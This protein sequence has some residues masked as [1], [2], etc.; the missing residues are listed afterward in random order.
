MSKE[1]VAKLEQGRLS[2]T[3]TS[4]VEGQKAL[5]KRVKER[6]E[7]R[8]AVAKA[9][10]E[11]IIA[12]TN[13][14][15]Q[16]DEKRDKALDQS[17]KD[18]VSGLDSDQVPTCKKP[19]K[20]E[21]RV[22]QEALA[23]CAANLAAWAANRAKQ[24]GSLRET[25]LEKDAVVASTWFIGNGTGSVGPN[26]EKVQKR[27]KAL[28]AKEKQASSGVKQGLDQIFESIKRV[29]QTPTLETA[30]LQELQQ[31]KA[32][33]SRKIQAQRDDLSQ[34]VE[35][36]REI[37][38]EQW[39]QAQ[40]K[41]LAAE[42]AESE[43]VAQEA[44]QVEDV[45]NE[46]ANVVAL[47]KKQSQENEAEGQQA[48][49]DI[50]S[51]ETL[52]SALQDKT[53]NALVW[54]NMGTL[55][56]N[57]STQALFNSAASAQKDYR[58]LRQLESRITQYF[59]FLGIKNESLKAELRALTNRAIGKLDSIVKDWELQQAENLAQFKR[60]QRL[61]QA[62][63][64]S[65]ASSISRQEQQRLHLAKENWGDLWNQ[66]SLKA[67]KTKEAL[68]QLRRQAQNQLDSLQRPQ[69]DK[70][71]T[72]RL[73][74]LDLENIASSKASLTK[75][76]LDTQNQ[77]SRMVEDNLADNFDIQTGTLESSAEL[78]AQLTS[79]QLKA[80]EA[81]NK[82]NT[83]EFAS[84]IQMSK[85]NDRKNDRD[86]SS[87][88]ED[89]GLQPALFQH[90]AV[91]KEQQQ[92]ASNLRREQALL[93][94]NNL[95]GLQQKNDRARKKYEANLE[96]FR[97]TSMLKSADL[98]ASHMLLAEKLQYS[99]SQAISTWKSKLDSI[100]LALA[101][102]KKDFSQLNASKTFNMIKLQAQH[103]RMQRLWA[104]ELKQLT[105][106]FE[107]AA[108]QEAIN[109]AEEMTE[110]QHFFEKAKRTATAESRKHLAEL[111]AL[112][113]ADMS[114]KKFQALEYQGGL[115]E[116]AELRLRDV[117]G[118]LSDL[119]QRLSQEI[120]D[121]S[122]NNRKL[123]LLQL[124]EGNTMLMLNNRARLTMKQTKTRKEDRAS[125]ILLHQKLR[126]LEEKA[127][128]DSE[129][130]DIK[131][132]RLALDLASQMGGLIKKTDEANRNRRELHRQIINQH[133]AKV[134]ELAS[135]LKILQNSS[136]E[137]ID[138]GALKTVLDE[139]IETEKKFSTVQSQLKT[140][141][142]L[143][144]TRNQLAVQQLKN[145]HTAT[146]GK[147]KTGMASA[148]DVTSG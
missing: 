38:K 44:S 26:V 5:Q 66:E 116:D 90:Q 135:R 52:K 42:I 64:Q 10:R 1:A 128:S 118:R 105:E 148:A 71:Y 109:H 121:E 19:A 20:C 77:R 62:K 104:R 94:S 57:E 102:A 65:Q 98:E 129:I 51:Y 48:E 100:K 7:Q 22:C 59:K 43:G 79:G 95:S 47:G 63:L 46:L 83:Q 108:V 82:A 6:I 125:Q 30:N 126:L 132:N 144:E 35:K 41:I 92:L 91:V 27:L 56:D 113:Y 86:F 21:G 122:Q 11:K 53:R 18:S 145:E 112:H 69:L 34:T 93:A 139:W 85:D 36:L 131:R 67:Q 17:I 143:S 23:A 84:L 58:R 61:I 16:E 117:E 101:A 120:A 4:E 12:L 99:M 114:R 119:Q 81:M 15:R 111:K 8:S 9:Q 74:T 32:E 3:K 78:G 88:L 55:L 141:H 87:N 115:R 68:D 106:E 73:G 60:N 75:T 28:R 137:P 107:K 130:R 142:E 37:V 40:A 31:K 147:F 50:R 49:A 80:L 13:Q 103:A 39:K 25:L 14:L 134:D 133:Q 33:S 146:L 136:T 72:D 70:E 124:F 24:V 127:Q 138:R 140:E 2:E 89:L 97:Q 110:S 76:V 96:T 54:D 123:L 29:K 45:Q